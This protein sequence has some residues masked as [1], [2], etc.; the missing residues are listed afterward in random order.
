MKKKI[1]FYNV[2]IHVALLI[3]FLLIIILVKQNRELK[4]LISGP[5]PN[6]LKVGE[7]I[8][9]FIFENDNQVIKNFHSVNKDKTLLFLFNTKCPYC[10]RNIPNWNALYDKLSDKVQIMGIAIDSLKELQK[11]REGKDI[12][13]PT[14]ATTETNFRSKNKIGAIP[15]TILLDSGHRIIDIFIGVLNDESIGK[16]EE[17]FEDKN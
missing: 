2:F 4:D 5:P 6:N 1:N 16:L 10:T 7:N 3:S 8:G 15:Q 9:D 12:I 13:Y 14:F 11:Y 17:R